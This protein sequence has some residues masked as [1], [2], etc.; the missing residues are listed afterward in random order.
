MENN[1][2]QAEIYR[3]ERK[4]RLAKAAAKS[5]KKS[6]KSMKTKKIVKKVVAIV[7]AV[8][9]AVGAVGG[10]L[11]FFDIPEKTV[12]I[13]VDGIEHKISLAE[14]NYYYYQSWYSFYNYAQQYEQYGA[15]MGVSMT[16][17]DYSK[18]PD[19]QEYTEQSAQIAGVPVEDLGSDEPTWADA[20]T[21]SA[22]SQLV[23][24]KYGSSKA[25]EAGIELTED[26]LEE[27][28]TQIE[29]VR[30]TAKQNDYSLDRWLRINF[31]AGVTEKVI[32]N[33]TVESTLA[34]KYYEK[35]TEDTKAT[36]T[37]DRINEQY[38]SA[39]DDYDITDIRIYSFNSTLTT[40]DK[41]DLTEEE[42]QKKQEEATAKAKAE[43][44]AFAKEVTDEESFIAEAQKAILTSDN[45]STL[46][47]EES[48]LL[49]DKSYATLSSSYNEEL[50]KWAFDDARKVGDVKVITEENIFYVVFMK[51]LPEKDTSASSADVRH[52]LCTFPDK[53]TDGTSTTKTD[54]NGNTVANIT[55]ATKQATKAEAQKVLDEYLKNP[56][57]DNFIALAKSNSDDT[58]TVSE[59]G[60]IENV[61]NDGTYVQQ[62]TDWAID[63]ARKPGE[64]GII[65]TTYGYH[66]MYFVEA[67]EETWYLA[68]QSEL[69]NEEL[70]K[71]VQSV[72]DAYVDSVNMDSL[73][74][75]WT[76]GKQNK[77]IGKILVSN[78]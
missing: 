76:V 74:I 6:P 54:D 47:A 68:I 33:A 35:I 17:F 52:I 15:G 39:K 13:S 40:A 75:G 26:E 55:E 29:S 10:V 65:E 69:T 73:F 20:F 62:F 5:A 71:N 63:E 61:A 70:Q 25:D 21:Y 34:S 59:G 1:K 32:Y 51:S 38:N 16:G 3:A 72:I 49:E 78:A 2:T 9:I 67:N 4:E 30:T 46:K 44:E 7:L 27:I 56:T 53:N 64:T 36:I 77:H 43:A 42:I 8:V 11:S 28:N 23:Y 14:V 66:V 37:D 60:L 24:A 22:V 19:K 18:T 57:E 50:A 12:K 45:D 58:G 31:G 41:T 48:T